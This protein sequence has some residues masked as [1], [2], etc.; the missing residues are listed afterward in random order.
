MNSDSVWPRLLG[1]F[2]RNILALAGGYLLK[3]GYIDQQLHDDILSKGQA[4]LLGWAVEGLAILWS[5]RK[6]IYSHAKLRLAA[7]RD[8]A[9]GAHS[10]ALAANGITP[11][12]APGVVRG[13]A[14][15]DQT[16][17]KLAQDYAAA[18]TPDAQLQLLPTLDAAID[19]FERDVMP[20]L[21]FGGNI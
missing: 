5:A 1:S 21:H 14:Q 13:I 16:L 11:P 3:K 18:Q 6:T 8:A 2:I 15:L 17:T 4:Q 19:L 10:L 20:L 7:L 12:P 9:A